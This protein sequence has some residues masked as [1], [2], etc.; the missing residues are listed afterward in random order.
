MVFRDI[1]IS[2]K[3]P[4]D[5]WAFKEFVSNI[6]ASNIEENLRYLTSVPHMG[7]TPVEW[8][9]AE[10]LRLD[11]LKFGIDKA[12]LTTYDVML[13]YPDTSK[14]SGVQ[15][16][17]DKGQV[18]FTSSLMEDPVYVER[19]GKVQPPQEDDIVPAFMAF[20]ASGVINAEEIV[21]VNYGRYE[22]FLYVTKT[23]GISLEGRIIMVRFG[24]IF[25]GNKMMWA[26]RFGVI[27]AIIFSDPSDYHPDLGNEAGEAPYPHSWWLPGSGIQRGTIEWV[28]GDQSTPMYPAI[29]GAYR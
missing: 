12:E 7:G 27:G 9:Q 28:D 22:D 11:W 26:E 24:K 13:N 16:L 18:K 23:L 25:R 3:S 15:I 14:Y 17:N 6:N 10:K 29:E 19:M 2:D 5:T 1:S 21:Y 4:F 20:S 8:D